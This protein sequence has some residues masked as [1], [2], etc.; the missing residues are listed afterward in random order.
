MNHDKL[1]ATKLLCLVLLCGC[2]L[3]ESLRRS[4]KPVTQAV[5]AKAISFP[6]PSSAKEIY[7]VQHAGGMQE[8]QLLI[9][10][11]MDAGELEKAVEAIVSDHNW[12]FRQP[13][14]YTPVP[15]TDAP[16]SPEFNQLLP[17]LWWTPSAI[18]NGYYCGS[19]A[20]RP[21]HVWVDVSQSTVY[22]CTHD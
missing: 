6:F 3:D 9:R 20:G 1:I 5:A 14:R 8:Y 4:D 15:I 13:S 10:F 21:F 17:I 2:G 11:E 12:Q 19:T 18:T 22:W 7:Y 16:R